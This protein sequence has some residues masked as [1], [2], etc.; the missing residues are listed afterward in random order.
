MISVCMTSY[1]GEKYIKTQILS[2]L[3]QL[4]K[5][6]ELIISDDQSTDG[7]LDII[8]SIH[9]PR[10]KLFHHIRSKELVKI[11]YSRNFYLVSANFENAL[12]QARGDF[13]FLSDQDDIW[14]PNKVSILTELLEKYNCV[15]CD[16]EPIDAEGNKITENI[17]RKSSVS[18]SLLVNM[19]NTPFLGCCMAFRKSVLSYVLPFPKK[20][21]GHDLW[22]G[23]LCARFDSFF[24]TGKKLHQYR[25]HENNVSPAVT[26]N[27]KNPLMI[28]ISYRI[29]LLF[30][31]LLRA[32]KI[33]I[34]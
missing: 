17:G 22:I 32:F 12:R 9:D 10:I 27:S 31:I 28:K 20:C 3:C 15:M 26:K 21:I 19:K 25:I 16:N 23:L 6:D 7:T 34:V 8:R 18:K 13:I 33:R 5:T 2:I 29:K 14:K 4:S 11:K 1:N 30:L 24:Y